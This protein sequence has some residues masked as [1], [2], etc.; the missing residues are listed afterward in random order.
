MPSSSL[1]PSPVAVNDDGGGGGGPV[2]PAPAPA[3]VLG[4]RP[5]PLGVSQTVQ[6]LSLRGEGAPFSFPC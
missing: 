2:L 5:T 1:A 3:G 6:P 4:V